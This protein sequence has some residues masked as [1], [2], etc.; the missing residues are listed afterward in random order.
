MRELEKKSI[1]LLFFFQVATN[2]RVM[3]GCNPFRPIKLISQGSPIR[4][5][6][7]VSPIFCVTLNSQ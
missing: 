3:K 6:G 1:I 5:K 2:V 7:A 4:V